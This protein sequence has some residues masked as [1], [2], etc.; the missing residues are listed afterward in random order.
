MNSPAG[1]GSTLVVIAGH[2]HVH[3]AAQQTPVASRQLAVRGG[4]MDAERAGVASDGRRLIAGEATGEVWSAG[5]RLQAAQFG[6]PGQQVGRPAAR[7]VR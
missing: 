4:R 2:V 6:G 3:R 7:A 1:P 5:E